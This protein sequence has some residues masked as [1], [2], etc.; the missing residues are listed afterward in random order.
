MKNMKKINTGMVHIAK[1]PSKDTIC[2]NSKKTN[3]P[4]GREV[5]R[6]DGPNKQRMVANL[7]SYMAFARCI[8]Y[9]WKEFHRRDIYF[10]R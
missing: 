3:S 5:G 6:E 8:K 9:S 10:P 4:G 2:Q 1:E 7:E